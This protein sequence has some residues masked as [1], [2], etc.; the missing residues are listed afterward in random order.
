MNRDAYLSQRDVAGFVEWAGHLVRSE[1]RLNH[2]Y[3]EKRGA[4]FQCHTLYEA[5][6]LYRWRGESFTDMLRNFDRFREE[7]GNIGTIGTD[8]DQARFVA[9]ARAVLKWGG[10][11][12]LTLNEWRDM[13]PLQLRELISEVRSKLDPANADTYLLRGFKYMGSGYSKIYAALI[14]GLPIYDSRVACALLCLVRLYC[15]DTGQHRTP[16]LLDLG[17]PTGRG[18]EGGRCTTPSIRHNQ[19]AKYALAN[20]RFAWLMQA[21]TADPGEFGNLPEGQRV[22]ALQSALFMLGYARLRD[23]AIVKGR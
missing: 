4:R 22:D 20:L 17:I 16:P 3:Q 21:L 18:N 14:P 7:F 11:N 6:Q 15:R 23:D 1:R 19:E 8:G 12:N 5:F 2:K 10:I 13:R 9:N